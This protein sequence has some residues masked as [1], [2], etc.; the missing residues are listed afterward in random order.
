MLIYLYTQ[1]IIYILDFCV[2]MSN[3]DAFVI[4]FILKGI[5]E[6]TFHEQAVLPEY[7]YQY[8]LKLLL[9]LRNEETL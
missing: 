2:D 3:Y 8:Y 7:P 5:Y 6:D 9:L 4:M 1:D